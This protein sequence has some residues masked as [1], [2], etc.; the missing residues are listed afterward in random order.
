[1]PDVVSLHHCGWCGRDVNESSV[2]C[3]FCGS[4]IGPDQPDLP[5]GSV[6]WWRP[7]SWLFHMALLFPI[8]ALFWACS[9][10]GVAFFLAM[11]AFWALALLALVWVGRALL[12]LRARRK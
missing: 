3:A 7:P 5:A 2:T 8:V 1:M 6:F 12:Y 11:A 4:P 9:V 10:P